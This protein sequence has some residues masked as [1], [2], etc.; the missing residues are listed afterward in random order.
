MS[1]LPSVTVYGCPAI[2]TVMGAGFPVNGE[3]AEFRTTYLNHREINDKA[4][5]H[6][7]LPLQNHFYGHLDLFIP[8]FNCFVERCSKSSCTPCTLRFLRSVR[9]A[10]ELLMTINRGALISRQV[11]AIR[12]HRQVGVCPHTLSTKQ[13]YKSTA[14]QLN[15]PTPIHAALPYGR[16]P[17]LCLSL[18]AQGTGCFLIWTG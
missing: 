8:R 14:Q 2:A 12:A 3:F 5:R 18:S 4:G 9:L 11:A 13:F 6:V 10:L 1:G 17:R 16:F 7:G 15:N